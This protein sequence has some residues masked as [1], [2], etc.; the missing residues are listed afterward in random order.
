VEEFSD[1]TKEIKQSYI[2][3]RESLAML[4]QYFELMQPLELKDK[5]ANQGNI[6]EM[7]WLL[8]MERGSE[9]TEDQ[10]N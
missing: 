7:E 10:G 1:I 8:K 4:E 9:D 5:E 3:T 2:K 6:T